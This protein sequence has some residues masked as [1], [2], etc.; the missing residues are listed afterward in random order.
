MVMKI[1]TM[2]ISLFIVLALGV[3]ACSAPSQPSDPET[4]ALAECL[5][6]N[7]FSM[8]GADWCPHCNEQK[9]QFGEAFD[10]IDYVD[11]EVDEQQCQQAD[12]QGIPMWTDDET[13][14][15]GTQSLERLAELSGCEYD[16]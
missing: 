5:T 1:N 4:T 8:Y 16:A 7:D 3:S 10:K 15:S 12:V 6:E 11:C 13:T 14:V 9:D 2:L